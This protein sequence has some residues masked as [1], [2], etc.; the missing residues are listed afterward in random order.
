MVSTFSR[1]NNAALRQG[2]ARDLKTY[3]VV[4]RNSLS[5]TLNFLVGIWT[6][7]F[8]LGNFLGSTVSGALVDIYGFPLTSTM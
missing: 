6:A 8:Y 4:A 7:S 3:L 1:A 5:G 2:F